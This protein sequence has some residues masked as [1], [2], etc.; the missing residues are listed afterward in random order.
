MILCPV[1]CEYEFA[2]DDDYEICMVCKWENDGLQMD[3]LDCNE[4]ANAISLNQAR[5]KWNDGKAAYFAQINSAEIR[6]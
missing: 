3:E 5:A 2:M 1:C 4:G 6:S